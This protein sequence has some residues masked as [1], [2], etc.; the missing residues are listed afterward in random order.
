MLK[1]LV[2]FEWSYQIK[3][4]SFL[5]FTALFF[6]WGVLINADNL[7]QW[8]ALI[9]INSPYRLNFFIA[10]T[11]VPTVF[12]IMIF[13]VN[14]VL[15]DDEYKFDGII[16]GLS[17]EPRLLSRFIIVLVCSLVLVSCIVLGL[18]AGMMAPQ[19]DPDKVTDFQ[20]S[21]YLWPWLV[22][23]LPNVLIS[24]VLLFAVTVKYRNPLV[25]YLLGIALFGVFWMSAITIGAPILGASVI[26][27]PQVVTVFALLDPFGVSAFFQHTQFW[28]P[29]EKNSQLVSLDGTLLINRVVWL[30]IALIVFIRTRKSLHNPAKNRTPKA[31][32]Q[33]ETINQFK[34]TIMPWVE[35]YTQ[36]FAYTLQS[37]KAMLSFEVKRL[38]SNF[39]FAMVMLI[40][41][42]VVMATAVSVGSGGGEFSGDYPTT[43]ILI[44]LMAEVLSVIALALCVYYSAEK[45]WQE[46]L[47]KM[48]SLLDSASIATLGLY[49]A[50]LLS[51]FVLP[52]LMITAIIV[53]SIPYQAF[54][55]YYRFEVGHYLSLYY[56]FGLPLLIQTILILFIQ[57]R[58]AATRFGNKYLGMLSSGFALILLA[59]LT[60]LTGLEHPLLQLNQFPSLLRVHSEL[61]GYGLYASQ[62]SSFA[63]FWSA[64]A[65]IIFV[66][67]L[68]CWQRGESS[69]GAITSKPLTKLLVLSTLALAGVGSFM[70]YQIHW[71]G[72]YQNYAQKLNSAQA[73]EVKY[74]QYRSLVSP[75]IID[76]KTRVDIYPSQP[77]YHI[78]AD[79][80]LKN[81]SDEIIDKIFV[82]A[83]KALNKMEIQGAAMVLRDN[84][85]NAYLFV[86]DQPMLPG[87]QLSMSFS[88]KHTSTPFAIDKGIVANGSFIQHGKFEPLMGYVE[89]L[90]I[91][92]PFE[93]QKRGLPP[94]TEQ[95]SH[96]KFHGTKRHFEAIVS[97][98]IDQTAITSGDLLKRWTQDGRN[99]FHYK[100]KPSVYAPNLTYFSARY[101]QQ[102][103]THQGIDI[104]MYSHPKHQSNIDEMIRATKA[105]LDYSIENFGAYPYKSLRL[106]EVPNYHP[107]GGQ[108]S[109]GVVALTEGL[110]N[111]NYADGSAI[112]NVA[113]NVIHEVSHQWWGEKLVPQMIAGE[114][115][116]VESMAKYVEVAVLQRLYGS[117]MPRAL[118]K[119]SQRRYFSGRAFSAEKEVALRLTTQNYLS[120]GKGPV[121]LLALK[122]LI[123]ETKLNQVLKRFIKNHQNDTNATI[124]DLIGQLNEVADDQQRRLIKDWFNKIIE[125]DLS[126]N[127]TEVK[128]LEDERYSVSFDLHAKRQVADDNGVF[129]ST[130]IDEAIQIGIFSQQP[131][132][133]NGAPIYLRS[134]QVKQSE[135]RVTVIVNEKPS[136]L[137]VDPYF[138][139]LDQDLRD[140]MS[141]L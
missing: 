126:V 27:E 43:E 127:E 6:A 58:L 48:D 117:A 59:N 81:T 16:G 67:T 22:F 2:L 62:F 77:S 15:R 11:S 23:S 51:L 47:L 46:R 101:Q 105:T 5:L 110:Y 94:L 135:T 139:R 54:S 119:Y 128:Q 120:Y 61:A 44:G 39:S 18:M 9:D 121:I 49:A 29:I 112:N 88:L 100:M 74:G 109:A 28:T 55:G 63:A 79:Y 20:I 138:T 95:Q 34:P 72:D 26:A 132:A 89:H 69:N 141:Q 35:Q 82:T 31:L 42:L 3:Q 93:R 86:L 84:E 70:F 87:A 131:K 60:S 40:W 24:S 12:S 19:L 76:M 115:V 140:N 92:D 50:K 90:Q 65:I 91:N 106:I 111:Q 96:A 13:C 32:F 8:M 102:T 38:I 78:S 64:M 75:Q 7:A 97:T 103:V 118:T 130:P 14:S 99:Y 98:S 56:Y 124:D 53:I 1:S 30:S 17:V 114:G 45:V 21:H 36:T 104:Q 133:K 52:L 41:C 10:L 68:R 83:P 122:E 125:Y 116:L 108:A 113:R 73:Y 66:F 37:F 33:P 123:G 137:V 57:V 85:W 71:E 25:T 134:H 107:F 129:S 4:V 80:K 136:Y